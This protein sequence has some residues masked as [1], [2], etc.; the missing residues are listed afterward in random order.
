MAGGFYSVEL[1]T[2][3]LLVKLS[4]C[5]SLLPLYPRRR[6]ASNQALEILIA[7][8]ARARLSWSPLCSFHSQPHPDLELPHLS[9]V[10]VHPITHEASWVL[11]TRGVV[12][13]E[14]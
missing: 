11:R 4:A 3:G 12:H 7:L 2:K 6:M 10:L 1:S 13:K 9:E 8:Y 5:L 14:E